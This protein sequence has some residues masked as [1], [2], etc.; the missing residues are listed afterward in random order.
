[1]VSQVNMVLGNLSK[2]HP[3]YNKRAGF[4]IGGFAWFQGWNDMVS[5]NIYPK[6][7]K[8]GGYNAYSKLLTHFIKDVRKDFKTPNMPFAIGVLGVGGPTKDYESPR[9]KGVHQ[10]YRDAMAAP[11]SMPEF[12]GTVKAVLTENFWPSDVDAVE[13]KKA[14]KKELSAKD[15]HL[16][17][18][19]KSNF[20]FHYL[21]NI[22][23]YSLIGEAL[24]KAITEVKQYE[25]FD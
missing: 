22:K 1:M 23:C 9:Y 24:A 14:A 10:Y 16:L 18:I 4:E 15:K 5:G 25:F 19:G 6:R 11:A 8:P 3:A 13:K 20:G 7:Y 2:Y 21:G 12:K 17:E